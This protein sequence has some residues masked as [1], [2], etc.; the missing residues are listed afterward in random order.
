MAPFDQRVFKAND[1]RGAYPDELDESFAFLLGRSLGEELRVGRAAVG[2]DARLSSPSL[3]GALAA[4]LRAAGAQVGALGL[5]PIELL[6]HVM[7]SGRGFDLGVMVTASHN[8]PRFNGFKVVGAGAAPLT[9]RR[10][11]DRVRRRISVAAAPLH[12]RCEPPEKSVFAESDYARFAA[13]ATGAEGLGALKVVVDPGNGVGGLLWRWAGEVCAVRPIEMNFEPD[14]RFP[15]HHPNPALLEN[16]L[17][18]RERVLAEGADLGL[19]HDG[20]ADR[21]VAVLGDGHVLDGGETAAALCERMFGRAPAGR[22][23]LSMTVSRRVLDHFRARGVEPLLVPVGHAK[24][25][26]AMRDDPSIAFAGE[27]SGHYFY[28]EFHCSESSLITSLHLLNLSAAGRLRPFVAGLPGPW[29]APDREPTFPLADRAEA[30]AAC[31]R[32][33]RAAVDAFPEPD[34]ITCEID[35]QVRR[36]CRPRDI[37][38]SEGVR[39]DYPDWWFCIRP[40]GTEPL[41]RLSLESRTAERLEEKLSALRGL[42]SRHLSA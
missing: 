33:A 8:P 16:L 13:T 19:A 39:V 28:R 5:C 9:E 3:G 37:D 27:Q 2:W 38:G 41:I 11:L 10:G 15:A 20:D 32:V 30:L 1:I 12:P 14:G 21:T 40:S 29:L 36:R 23:A 6:Y 24:A 7:G 35:W 25:K 4:G 31:R 42:V 18:L 34:E 22:I 26:R 17:P